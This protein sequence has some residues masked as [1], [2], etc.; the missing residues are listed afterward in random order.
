MRPEATNETTDRELLQRLAVEAGMPPLRWP[1]SQEP[2]RRSLESVR[3]IGL[4]LHSAPGRLRVEVPGLRGR[5]VTA[6]AL[7]DRLKELPGVF[8]V[9]AS[10]ATGRALVTF[11]TDQVDAETVLGAA[12][13][14]EVE[15]AAPAPRPRARSAEGGDRRWAVAG[16]VVGEACVRVLI[17]HVA[18]ELLPLGIL[19][20][21]I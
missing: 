19:E 11:N 20:S 17:S 14:A 8:S 1:S 6:A 4:Y 9:E 3:S 13:P 18:G 21:L 7:A 10:A 5:A 12:L 15:T 2:Q 16:R